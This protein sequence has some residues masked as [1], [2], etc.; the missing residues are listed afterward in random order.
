MGLEPWRH[1]P[2]C[3][4]KEGRGMVEVNILLF[5]DFDTMDAFGVAEVLG[6]LPM[7]FHMNYLS[8]GGSI[9][10]SMQGVKVW[11]EPLIPEK[12][13]GMVV[14]PGGRGARRLLFQDTETLELM[15]KTVGH[16]Q[17]CLMI[18]G[19]TA[20]V[21]QTG[22]LYRRRIAK[23]PVDQ[24]WKRMFMGG[25][26]EIEGA[27]WVADGKFYSSSDT[28]K[29][30]AMALNIMADLADLDLAHN[31]AEEMGYEWDPDD[32]NIYE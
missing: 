27:S 22:L 5:D 13:Q 20:L 3:K 8:V 6:R 24:N 2:F 7:Y 17:F 16:A 26:Y 4:I 25:V 21:A 19:G 23:C 15:K 29:G 18:G 30:I 11:T 28:M 10:N 1:G 9:V 31:L 32:E 14:I 12:I